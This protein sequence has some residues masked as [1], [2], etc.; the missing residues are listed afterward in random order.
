[1]ERDIMDMK[2][3]FKVLPTD[4]EEKGYIIVIGKHLATTKYFQ[5]VKP[6]KKQ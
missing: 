1:M 2:D 4:L 6:H 5:R 3:V